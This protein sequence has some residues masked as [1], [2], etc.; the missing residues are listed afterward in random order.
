MITKYIMF[1]GRMISILHILFTAY[2]PGVNIVIMAL[3]AQRR[4]CLEATMSS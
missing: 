1:M 4:P 2:G 3:P